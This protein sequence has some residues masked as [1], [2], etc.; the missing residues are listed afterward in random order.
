[1]EI[2]EDSNW[3]RYSRSG[4]KIWGGATSEA[5]WAGLLDGSDLFSFGC[6][7][8]KTEILLRYLKG[9]NTYCAQ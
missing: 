8:E 7:L 6:P 5:A 3:S 2:L 1:M 4:T 9:A